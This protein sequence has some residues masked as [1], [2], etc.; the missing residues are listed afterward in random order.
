MKLWAKTIV[1]D[2]ITRNVVY[3]YFSANNVDEFISVLQEVC[4][5]MDIPTPIATNVN[6]NH[7]VMFNNTR[8]KS[9]DF[10][11]SID[12]DVLDVEAVPEREKT[13]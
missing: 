8:F 11:E 2:K 9:R 10:V 4:G 7:F 12:F 1:E 3:E 5:L 6:F 13:K